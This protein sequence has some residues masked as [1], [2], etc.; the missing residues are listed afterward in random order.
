M[1]AEEMSKHLTAPARRVRRP[2]FTPMVTAILAGLAVV[3]IFFGAAAFVA[4]HDAPTHYIR[5]VHVTTAP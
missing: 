1:S 4:V 5:R 2:V 3:A